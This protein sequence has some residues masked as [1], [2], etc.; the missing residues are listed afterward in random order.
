MSEK[1]NYSK[2]QLKRGEDFA[3]LIASYPKEKQRIILI[4]A[5][6]FMAGLSAKNATEDAP[7]LLKKEG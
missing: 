5:D 2:E 6:A 1:K 7:E 3:R 4:V